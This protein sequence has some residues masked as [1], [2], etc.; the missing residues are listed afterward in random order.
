MLNHKSIF[1]VCIVL[2]FLL[3]ACPAAGAAEVLQGI[4]SMF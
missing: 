4:G 1:I 3:F 2:W